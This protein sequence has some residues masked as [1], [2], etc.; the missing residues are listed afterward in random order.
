[1][2]SQALGFMPSTLEKAALLLKGK[3][4]LSCSEKLSGK[5]AMTILLLGSAVAH[6]T[7]AMSLICSR[8]SLVGIKHALDNKTI[9]LVEQKQFVIHLHTRFMKVSILLYMMILS[10][11]NSEP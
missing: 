3:Q 8:Y 11:T 5:K 10:S 2:E 4:K 6:L 7:V 1:M 9:M